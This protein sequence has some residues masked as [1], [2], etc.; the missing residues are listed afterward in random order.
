MVLMTSVVLTRGK[1]SY[2]RRVS[3]VPQSLPDFDVMWTTSHQLLVVCSVAGM[4][5]Q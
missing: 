2:R 3:G 5:L 1:A 4:S